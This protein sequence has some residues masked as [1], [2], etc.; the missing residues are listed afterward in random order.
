[1]RAT[2]RLGGEASGAGVTKE[3]PGRKGLNYVQT[4]VAYRV[5]FFFLCRSR[6]MMLGCILGQSKL[7]TSQYSISVNRVAGLPGNA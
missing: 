1:M 2:G 3:R 5:V 6:M 7:E 4:S